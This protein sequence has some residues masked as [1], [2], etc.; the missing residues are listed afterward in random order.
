MRV[1]NRLGSVLTLLVALIA[2]AMVMG[3]L[4]AGLLIPAVGSAGL[5]SNGSIAL[6]NGLPATFAMNPLA[7]QS[8]ILAADGSTIATPFNENRVVV[9][10]SK[11][12][13]IM[14]KAQVAIEDQRFYQHGAID[15]K[16]LLRAVSSNAQGG[17]L[18]GA[19]T[20]TQ[21]YV[22]VALENQA[23]DAGNTNAANRAVTQD[24]LQGYVRKLQQLR[25]AIAL[26][27]KY[28]KDQ[29]LDGYLNIVYF[30]DQ[31]YGIEA[32][33]E[34]YFSVH[35]SQ[36]TLPEAALLAGVV[37]APTTFDPVTNPKNSTA[38]R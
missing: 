1:I 30:G 32:A 29:I 35:A 37:N 4:A 14:R 11:V 5:A 10:L 24:G 2:T 7:Q 23:R 3:L 13:P 18:Q 22:K 38:R 36:L 31:Q 28:S 9:P 25:Y 6:F 8:R 20:L 21:Q 27:K 26:E 17:G 15:P 33:A 12:A 19:S 16:G 34:H